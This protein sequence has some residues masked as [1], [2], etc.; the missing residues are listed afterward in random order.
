MSNQGDGTKHVL[1][2]GAGVNT[3]A[4][5]ILLIR[6]RAPLDEVIFADTGGEVPE[7]YESV[8]L[9]RNYLA[10]HEVPFTIVETR[11]GG[12]DLYATAERRRVI[13]SV[14]WRWST[15]DFKVRPIYRYYKSLGAYVNQY[16]GIA[17]DEIHRMRDSRVPFVTNLY[18]LVD[19]RLTRKDCVSIIQAEGL[20][21]PEKSGCFF[22]PFNSTDRWRWL[23]NRHPE[24][25]DRAIALEENS[26]H[27]PSQRL[28]DQVFRNRDRV[29]LREF[30]GKLL[31]GSAITEVVDGQACGGDCMT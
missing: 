19:G 24:L 1:S 21:V 30:R 3:V 18:P 13:P 22:C 9:A 17:Y 31:T 10:E 23:L 14:K 7:T 25:F 8:E 12:R 6:D 16:I 4:L 2:F 20:P 5:M 28:T 11:P 27:F 29:T 26:K 15:R